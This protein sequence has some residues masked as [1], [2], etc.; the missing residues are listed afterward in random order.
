MPTQT[1]SFRSVRS[2]M[3]AAAATLSLGILLG[4]S[5]TYYDEALPSSMN[6]LFARTMVDQRSQELVFDRLYYRSA[7][8][9]RLLSRL[10]ERDSEV[11]EDALKVVV[12]EGVRWH[13]GKR[14][15]PED[16]C[17]TVDAM[18]NPNTP[19]TV[20][21]G[22]RE[23]LAG[24]EVEK[25]DNA[26]TIRFVRPFYNKKERLQFRLLP[27][28]AFRST[29]IRPDDSF[30]STPI[31]SGPMK[32]ERSSRAVTMERVDNLHYQTRIDRMAMSQGG[33]PQV[34]VRNVLLGAVQGVVAVTPP[35]R[36]DIGASEDASLKSYDLRSWWFIAINPKT[37]SDRRIRQA[38]NHFLDREQL[39]ELTIGVKPGAVN[40]PCQFISGPFVPSSPYYNHAI[41]E[42]VHADYTKAK[43][44]MK[45]VGAKW[46]D[47]RWRLRGRP[48]PLR[49]GINASLA[50]EAP[51][52]L[53]QVGNQLREA[54]FETSVYSES[55]DTWVR[56]A[57]TGQ[58]TG[59]YDM[60][61][62]KWSFGLVE[63]VDDLFH[64]RTGAEGSSN[65]F[66]YKN[67]QADA[68]IAQFGAAR[69]DTEAQDAYHALHALLAEDL[70][71]LFLWKLDTKSAWRNEVRDNIIAPYFYFSEFD[72][73]RM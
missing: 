14:L 13:D 65:I 20:A 56:D 38:L 28:H 23:V 8:T 6:P 32:A 52:L 44:L 63:E 9:N 73:W 26:A 46:V 39:R 4:S 18:L 34:Q 22:Y 3:T 27:K 40:P 11:G 5:I 53:A 55:A 29:A 62:G 1:S 49:I 50:P 54:G 12:R 35:L 43:G 24:C 41:E 68:L 31:G 60:L 25:K 69:T 33:D 19:S 70:P 16:V 51:D 2:A 17:F 58:L 36:Q 10:V 48:I 61:I 37:V 45:A 30:S 64:S 47:G 7:V 59:K 67:P 21:Q 66:N 72:D 42:V 15:G 57:V 71:Y